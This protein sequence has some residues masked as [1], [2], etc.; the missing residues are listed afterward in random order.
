MKR[1]TTLVLISI[2]LVISGIA[3][4]CGN[5]L[6][7]SRGEEV[8][9][10]VEINTENLRDIYFAGGCF[11]GVEEYF[12]RMPGVYNVTSG[13]ANGN[14]ENPSYDDVCYRETGHAETVHVQYDP[15]IISLK[16]LT[17]Q[18]F[19]IIDPTTVNQQGYDVGSQY[20]TGVYYTNEDD[21]ETIKAVFDGVQKNYKQ[22]IVTELLPLQHYYLAEE[23]HQDYLKKNPFGYCHI[24][25]SSLD[26]VVTEDMK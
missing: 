22:K 17:E 11:W 15:S 19:K 25:F 23:Y 12:S 24:D 8:K 18:F 1:L 26:D 6:P 10:P 7:N 3:A 2:L 13:Y 16:T 5:N 14:T 20:R 4:S 9:Q 21:L